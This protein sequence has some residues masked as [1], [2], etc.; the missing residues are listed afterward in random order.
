MSLTSSDVARRADGSFRFIVAREDPGHPNWIRTFAHNR[1][2]LIFRMPGADEPALP[3]VRRISNQSFS[4]AL[5][6]SPASARIGDRM[7]CGP[8]EKCGNIASVRSAKH[9]PTLVDDDAVAS[10]AKGRD[11]RIA[12]ESIGQFSVLALTGSTA[13]VSRKNQTSRPPLSRA[14]PT[15]LF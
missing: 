13:E 2:F 10:V 11:G 3:L 9:P 1:H 14:L 15:S 4:E 12:I 8:G 6:S 7:F 5:A